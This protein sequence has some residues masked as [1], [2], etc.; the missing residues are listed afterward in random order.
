MRFGKKRAVRTAETWIIG[1]ALNTRSAQLAELKRPK[2]CGQAQLPLKRPP[3]SA[4]STTG[5]EGKIPGGTFWL[6]FSFVT[7][8]WS[9]DMMLEKL[10]ITKTGLLTHLQIT[11]VRRISY[12]WSPGGTEIGDYHRLIEQQIP[13]LRRYARALTRDP[14]RSDDLVQDTLLRALAKEHC[15]QPGINIRA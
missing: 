5:P 14:E 3:A 9:V 11:I 13:R 1:G 10:V 12:G 8:P 15:W 6:A 4:P 2:V 7:N